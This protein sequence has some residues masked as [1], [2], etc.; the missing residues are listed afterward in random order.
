[1]GRVIFLALTFLL[2]LR[3]TNAQ[4]KA[5]QPNTTVG[6]KKA[7][8]I[9]N[10]VYLSG[11]LQNPVN[12]AADMRKMLSAKGFE[13]SACCDNLD[14]QGLDKAI[15]EW[16]N[17][18]QH[19][20]IALFYYSG[21]G[22]RLEGSDYLV[23]VDFALSNTQADVQYKA[24]ALQRLQD[25]M[26][27]R[28][29]RLN[30]II[31]DACRSNPFSFAK[32]LNPGLAPISAGIGT[33]IFFAAAEGKTA[34][35][36]DKGRNSL[37]TQVLLEELAQP[38][39]SLRNLGYLVR[40][41]V[42]ELSNGRQVPYVADNMVY[43][44]SLQS[45][46]VTT[47]TS[48]KDPVAAS[49]IISPPYTDSAGNAKS[50]G[51]LVGQ[52]HGNAQD[53]ANVPIV[54]AR[55][56]L[57]TDG[58]TAL[59][60]FNTDQSGNYSGSG[61]SP[62]AYYITLYTSPE[63]AVDRFDNV[64]VTAGTDTLQN[65]DLSRSDYLNKLPQDLQ[66][67]F[68]EARAK[69]A[70]IN[71]DNQNLAVLNNLLKQARADN[72]AKQYAD[73]ASLMQQA[74]AV[75]LDSA[76][77]WLEL[78]VA[79]TGLKKYPDAEVSLKRALDCDANAKNPNPDVQAAANNALG[80][81]Y[82]NTNRVSDSAAAYDAAVRLQPTNAAMFYTNEAIV[83]RRA[84]QTD[85]VITASDNAIAAD[86]NKPI[87]Y[88]LKAESLI[89]KATVDGKTQ[90]IISPPGTADAYRKYLELAPDGAMA[91][92]AKSVLAEID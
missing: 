26:L 52:L 82:A 40:D 16:T 3:P 80:E 83:F 22:L 21:H 49:D 27:E 28:G 75:R 72:A 87:P 13:V 11:S 84:G 38:T 78:G 89:S 90:K 54:N 88:Y 33:M 7:L 50:V 15:G 19:D 6:P 18:L 66:R 45:V 44:F 71:K 1:M 32:D 70:Q 51:E 46:V 65:F 76:V 56:V 63:K 41:H 42:Y 77:L 64:I 68:A 47:V 25:K 69:N 57:S 67:T 8:V 30:V 60:T 10:S 2:L 31:I 5:L 29:T 36:N 91:S 62:G 17:Q 34:D 86:P 37:F 12:D 59:Y 73:A 14:D 85:A 55:V 48:Y 4:D 92:E 23:P 43:D 24:Y 79:Q 9:G 35:D 81:V 39:I 61:I 74:T 53:P 20:D 58:K